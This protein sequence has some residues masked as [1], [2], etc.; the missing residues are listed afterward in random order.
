MGLAVAPVAL[1]AM[2]GTVVVETSWGAVGV[3]GMG[4]GVGR[5]GVGWVVV[6]MR[7]VVC[8]V[9]RQGSLG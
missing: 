3:R 7:E 5:V 1:V 8:L 4:V 2:V 6:G 9:R